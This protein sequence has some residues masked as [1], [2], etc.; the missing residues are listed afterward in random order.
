M[1]KIAYITLLT[2]LALTLPLTGLAKAKKIVHA[3]TANQQMLKHIPPGGQ[4]GY[5][6]GAA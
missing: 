4:S 6:P 5:G 2:T 1:K 3:T